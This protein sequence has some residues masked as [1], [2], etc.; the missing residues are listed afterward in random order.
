MPEP[1][2]SEVLLSVTNVG[3]PKNYQFTVKITGARVV[4][5]Q[6]VIEVIN[7]IHSAVIP[8][9]KHDVIHESGFTELL[10]KLLYFAK[11]H[12]L[13]G[14]TVACHANFSQ[15]SGQILTA[16]RSAP[17]SLTFPRSP[18]LVNHPNTI[19]GVAGLNHLHTNPPLG[20]RLLWGLPVLQNS[21][22]VGGNWYVDSA[23]RLYTQG[24]DVSMDRISFWLAALGMPIK[25]SQNIATAET[26]AL[27][28]GA[29]KPQGA[30][31]MSGAL[32]QILANAG[33]N[34]IS[35]QR[36]ILWNPSRVVMFRVGNSGGFCEFG[37]TGFSD[38]SFDSWGAKESSSTV[39]NVRKLPAISLSHT[40]KS[41]I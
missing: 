25:N 26:L 15:S 19:E 18:V 13:W 2:K 14:Q 17:Q 4:S 34:G 41:L 24:G 40:T 7:G 27:C 38:Y 32:S 28:L 30:L 5:S 3:L 11:Q 20:L 33:P 21:T 31:P 35:L 12:N 6:I 10:Y 9:S 8:L 39:W 29:A 36:S 22:Q 37:P 23:N 1:A 16:T